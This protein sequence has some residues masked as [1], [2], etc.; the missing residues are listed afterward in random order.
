MRRR[1]GADSLR[2]RNAESGRN[3]A[4]LRRRTGVPRSPV[5]ASITLG[6]AV[7]AT[8]RALS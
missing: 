3:A 8:I 6:A 2:S 4:A 5:D 7:T 1:L